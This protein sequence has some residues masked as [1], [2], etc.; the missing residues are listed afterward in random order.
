MDNG[1]FHADAFEPKVFFCA[2]RLVE[3]QEYLVNRV[4]AGDEFVNLL[5]AHRLSLNGKSPEQFRPRSFQKPPQ[6]GDV[7]L[8]DT[9]VR[10]T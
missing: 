9:V 3:I 6:A 7:M 2:G 5:F 8:V 10:V 4:P 1:I